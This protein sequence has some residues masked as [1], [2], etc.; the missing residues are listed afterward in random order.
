[1]V[2]P[3]PRPYASSY[4]ARASHMPARIVEGTSSLAPAWTYLLLTAVALLALAVLAQ[5]AAAL[6]RPGGSAARVLGSLGIVGVG[7]GLPLVGVFQ[8]NLTTGA[9]AALVIAGCYFLVQALT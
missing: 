2:E 4:G 6:D 5:G 9:R 3:E 7:V 8:P 1:M